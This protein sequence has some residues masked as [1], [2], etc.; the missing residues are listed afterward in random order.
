MSV[1][2]LGGA[3]ITFF[4]G[5]ELEMGGES[6]IL[7]SAMSGPGVPREISVISL[8]GPTVHRVIAFSDPGSYYR[9]E[10]ATTVTLV[11]GTV[12]GHHT[13]RSGNVVVALESCGSLSAPTA[14]AGTAASTIGEVLIQRRSLL[15]R[16]DP[17]Q[18][19]QRRARRFHRCHTLFHEIDLLRH[20]IRCRCGRARHLCMTRLHR[21]GVLLDARS[22]R[23]PL[24]L[25]ATGDV[26]LR[27]QIGETAVGKRRWVEI[28]RA[29]LM[30]RLMHALHPLHPLHAL[31]AWAPAKIG[32]SLR[33]GQR[34]G[35][36][37]RCCQGRS[38][39]REALPQDFSGKSVPLQ[40]EC[41]QFAAFACPQ[42]NNAASVALH[43]FY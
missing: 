11:R 18:I 19:T 3:L 37:R 6:I 15:G 28:A 13:D 30:H 4:D 25:L 24:C 32:A 31:H 2:P 14:T 23:L 43:L 9:V 8:L 5:S 39:A 10:S 17:V 42:R 16:Q 1:E 29:A 7:L 22:E 40:D 26:E 41:R 21:F 20:T 33:V 12:F 38:I 27:F 36:E 35:Q 34:N